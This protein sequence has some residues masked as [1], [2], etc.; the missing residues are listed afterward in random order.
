MFN[1]DK[2]QSREQLIQL[3]G[4]WDSFS[5][6]KSKIE[7]CCTCYNVCLHLNSAYYSKL[8]SVINQRKKT[9]NLSAACVGEGNTGRWLDSHGQKVKINQTLCVGSAA[10]SSSLRAFEQV[11]PQRGPVAQLSLSCK[12][13]AV[14]DMTATALAGPLRGVEHFQGNHLKNDN[15]WHCWDINYTLHPCKNKPKQS[16]RQKTSSSLTSC[17]VWSSSI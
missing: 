17:L 5:Q 15:L 8:Q 13:A 16:V 12:S 3:L 10:G 11:G 2:K 4:S 6:H 9:A 1:T 14:Q 7:S